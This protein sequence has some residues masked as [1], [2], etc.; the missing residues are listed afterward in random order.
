MLTD[1]HEIKNSIAPFPSTK[2][3]NCGESSAKKL[4]ATIMQKSWSD[5]STR[6][7]APPSIRPTPV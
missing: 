6:S 2:A 3:P 5:K 1:Q 4:L 7:I